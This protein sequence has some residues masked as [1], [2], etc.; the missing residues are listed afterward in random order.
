[1][2]DIKQLITHLC[3]IIKYSKSKYNKCKEQFV[4]KYVFFKP[5]KYKDIRDAYTQLEKEIVAIEN[6]NITVRAENTTLVLNMNL[7]KV[8]LINLKRTQWIYI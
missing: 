1:M 4:L 8:I 7:S 5:T 3:A 2:F 6:S